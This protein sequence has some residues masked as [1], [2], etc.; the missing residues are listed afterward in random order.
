MPVSYKDA[1]EKEL[2]IA[3]EY[4]KNIKNANFKKKF[5]T[6]QDVQ[7][8]LYGQLSYK[9]AL[10]LAEGRFNDQSDN[11]YYNRV[12]AL[13]ELIR[14]QKSRSIWS[15]MFNWKANRQIESAINRMAEGVRN[16]FNEDDKGKNEFRNYAARADVYKTFIDYGDKNLDYDHPFKKLVYDYPFTYQVDRNKADVP[17]MNDEQ[18][19][20]KDFNDLDKELRSAEHKAAL[21]KYAEKHEQIKRQFKNAKPAEKTEAQKY[22][23]RKIDRLNKSSKISDKKAT[24]LRAEREAFID[25]LD[26]AYIERNK[27]IRSPEEIA[28][29]EEIKRNQGRI[30]LFAT[31]VGLRKKTIRAKTFQSTLTTAIIRLRAKR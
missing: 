20:T 21:A 10:A 16:M 5:K 6:Q 24:A 14:Y 25:A 27:D 12:G 29:V 9:E 8:H 1:K 4:A 30:I 11:H 26:L 22:S 18:E 31:T 19:F 7:K 17:I 15:R 13:K 3:E 28:E 23:E 2:R